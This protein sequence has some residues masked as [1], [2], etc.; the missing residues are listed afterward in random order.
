MG[1]SLKQIKNRIKSVEG[2]R[3]IT[4][5]MELVSTLKLRR[6][7]ER[8]ENV[9]PYHDVLAEAIVGLQAGVA[10][11]SSVFAVQREVKRTC[12]VVI[13]GDRGLAGGYNANLFRLAKT[14]CAG[15]D[16]CILPVGKKALEFYRRSGCELVSSAFE[17]SALVGVGDCVQMAELVCRG[18]ADGSY[19]KVSVVYTRFN[20][21][22]SQTPVCEDILPLELEGV[23]GKNFTGSIIEGSADD[24]IAKIVPQYVSGILFAALCEA[25]A[26]EHG[27]RRT[28]MNAA[29]KNADEIIDSLMLKYNRARQAMI[30]QEITEIVSG[31]EA[32]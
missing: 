23:A 19:D 22:L 12:F 13:G 11:S 8:A 30:T 20:S 27:A 31:A 29:N 9:R 10:E 18:F 5:A 15:K 7:K 16:Y 3:Q 4:K 21:M 2:T 28:A 1:A 6:A 14:L 25:T 24:L 17:Y 26:S 32:L